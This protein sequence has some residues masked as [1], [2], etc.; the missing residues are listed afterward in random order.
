MLRVL[1]AYHGDGDMETEIWRLEPLEGER[2]VSMNWK[3][4]NGGCQQ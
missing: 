2:K 1:M 3:G 4:R